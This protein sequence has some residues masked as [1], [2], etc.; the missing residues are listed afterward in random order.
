MVVLVACR[1]VFALDGYPGSNRLLRMG[2]CIPLR[3]L[4]LHR[5]IATDL[6]EAGLIKCTRRPAYSDSWV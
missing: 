4:I 1:L 2:I 6:L 3:V 5:R